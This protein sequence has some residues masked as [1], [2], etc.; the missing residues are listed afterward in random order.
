MAGSAE[1]FRN[2][3]L[4]ISEKYEFSEQNMDK[5]LARLCSV[6]LLFYLSKRA[7]VSIKYLYSVLK[8]HL[9]IV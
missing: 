6:N 8:K 1:M 7:N 4:E 9:T 2:K 3:F 5:K